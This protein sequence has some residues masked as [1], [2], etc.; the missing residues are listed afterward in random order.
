MTDRPIAT[1]E[2]SSS[3]DALIIG[4]GLVPGYLLRALEDAG[5]RADLTADV[6]SMPDRARKYD[7]IFL[8]D[9]GQ[10]ATTIA[11]MLRV[12]D[13]KMLHIRTHPDE[14]HSEEALASVRVVYT[15]QLESWN[16][17]EITDRILSSLFA[18]N[19]PRVADLRSTAAAH[20]KSLKEHVPVQHPSETPALSSATAL[21]SLPHLPFRQSAARLGQLPPVHRTGVSSSSLSSSTRLKAAQQRLQTP[22]VEIQRHS[23]L[24]PIVGGIMTLVLIAVLAV[25]GYGF[26]HIHQLQQSLSRMQQ[27]VQVSDWN[28]IQQDLIDAQR[29]L[30]SLRHLQ[31]FIAT[32]VPPLRATRLM[33]DAD[34]IISSGTTLINSST[35]AVGFF[36]DFRFFDTPTF[37]GARIT[38]RE[39]ARASEKIERVR[40]SL[41]E[42]KQRIE[43]AHLSI[44]ARTQVLVF[45]TA[46]V[47]QLTA[48]QELLPI[49]KEL[50]AKEGKRT[51]MVLFQN[52]MELRPTGGFI[53]SFALMTVD[54]GKIQE[55]QILDVYDADGQL[56]GHVDP[57]APIRK[58][59]SQPNWFLRDSNFDPDFAVSATW[60]AWFLQKELGI[61][62]DGV[63]GVNLFFAQQLLR[64][65]GPLT[66]ADFGDETVYANTL[67]SKA[68]DFAT[69]DFFPGSSQKKDF[70][71]AVSK[72]LLARF[73]S[74]KSL[75]WMDLLSVAKTSFE[76]KYVMIFFTDPAAQSLVE[77]RGWAGR[78][79]NTRCT[80]QTP[81][82][83]PKSPCQADYLAVVEANLGVNKANYIA[84]KSVHIQ[85][86]VNTHGTIAT[87]LTL[88]YDNTNKQ[89]S[90]YQESYVN[91]VRIFV[92]KN[93]TLTGVTVNDSP[94]SPTDV[95]SVSYGADKHAFGFLVTIP[96]QQIA[97]VKIA[98]TIPSKLESATSQYQLIYQKQSGDKTGP[99]LLSVA[100]QAPYLLTPANFRASAKSDLAAAVDGQSLTFSSDTAVDRVFAFSVGSAGK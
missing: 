1:I 19:A 85:K 11:A 79:A 21:H 96:P 92:P 2:V 15:G 64:V 43:S 65:T 88:L 84:T 29:R 66:L 52:P 17:R 70:L 82:N 6:Q 73:S 34:A 75:P 40:T 35:D 25:A 87:I 26:W 20:P 53:G 74:T 95:D 5:C 3:P 68:H 100:N 39:I 47:E 13:G 44:P 83:T 28:G 55:W 91:Y 63:I 67:F 54:Q 72:S 38:T 42:T 33:T 69:G 24:L 94:L 30:A 48:A 22:S 18:S 56:T 60:A 37:D 7:Y 78:M 51:Y 89:D 81:D 93:T 80:P 10:S 27:H 8:F 61:S 46:G 4:N 97:E 71:T 9:A 59:L 23:L 32:A 76:E 98:Y 45:L 14:T 58:H 86:S 62:V 50:I 31:G 41:A 16:P 12:P 49:V 77:Q 99:L 90:R 36:R 57:P